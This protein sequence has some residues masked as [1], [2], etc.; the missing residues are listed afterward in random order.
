M[1]DFSALFLM[2]FFNGNAGN[3]SNNDLSREVISSPTFI[4]LFSKN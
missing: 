1:N 2:N 4:I 3:V